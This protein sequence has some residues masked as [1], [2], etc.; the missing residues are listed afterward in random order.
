[1]SRSGTP[2]PLTSQIG[3]VIFDAN[4]LVAKIRYQKSEPCSHE[5][6]AWLPIYDMSSGEQ[7]YTS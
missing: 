1:M 5:F 7:K 2:Y 6:S 4:P 3:R